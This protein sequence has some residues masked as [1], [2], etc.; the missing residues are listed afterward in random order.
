MEHE[1][2]QQLLESHILSSFMS[3]KGGMFYSEGIE[4]LK[5]ILLWS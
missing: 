1:K 3:Y 4:E 5:K 2:V